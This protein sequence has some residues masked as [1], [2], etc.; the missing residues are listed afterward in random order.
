[1][2]NLQGYLFTTN[3][4]DYCDSRKI[5][6]AENLGMIEKDNISALCAKK[7]MI[8]SDPLNFLF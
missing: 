1:M 4:I 3:L 8:A 7:K 2:A 5:L 6:G